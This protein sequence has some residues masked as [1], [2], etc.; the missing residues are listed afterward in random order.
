M[1]KVTGLSCM[2]HSFRNRTHIVGSPD[3]K[4]PNKVSLISETSQDGS[5]V[6]ML[7]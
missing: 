2:V 5:R 1:S 6:Y 4:D 7:P 3:Q